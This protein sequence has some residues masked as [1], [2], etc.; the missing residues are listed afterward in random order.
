MSNWSWQAYRIPTSLQPEATF[1]WTNETSVSVNC[2]RSHLPD[3]LTPQDTISDDSF[4]WYMHFL[5]AVTSRL[6]QPWQCSLVADRA[7]NTN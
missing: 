2:V 6:L 4:N 1:V 5:C 3:T 7:Q